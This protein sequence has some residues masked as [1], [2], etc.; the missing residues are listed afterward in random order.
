MRYKGLQLSPREVFQQ[1][2]AIVALATIKV[3]DHSNRELISD[4]VP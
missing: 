2:K 1:M 3:A 4:E